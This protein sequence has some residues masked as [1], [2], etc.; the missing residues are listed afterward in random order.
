MENAVELVEHALTLQEIAGSDA[1]FERTYPD[2]PCLI[3]CDRRQIGQVLNNL[4]K[5]A[6]EA[7]GSPEDDEGRADGR[8]AVTVAEGGG[9]CIIRIQDN[10][11]G[12]P[13]VPREKL[14]EPYVTHR[15]KGTGLGLAI[16]Q[17]IV[18]EH[19]GRLDLRNNPDGGACA[20]VMLPLESKRQT[21]GEARS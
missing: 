13:P 21:D 20:T 3:N 10:G 19:S 9:H 16:A 8:I 15:D 2:G 6:I 11:R 18:E 12:L 4:I 5:N 17:R 14:F 1:R 7:I